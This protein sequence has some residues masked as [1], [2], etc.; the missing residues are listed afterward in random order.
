MVTPRPVV[1][2]SRDGAGALLDRRQVES[3]LA[4]GELPGGHRAAHVEGLLAAEVAEVLG[5]LL[6]RSVEVEGISE[7]EG[8]VDL[9][10]A[11]EPDVVGVDVE[12]T[13]L[14][15][16]CTAGFCFLG[17]EAD[18][19][20][21]DEAVELGEADLVRGRGE[22]PVHVGGAC[23]GEK[24]GGVS[25]APGLPHLEVTGHDPGIDP[26]Q[27]VPQLERPSDVPLAGLRRHPEGGGELVGVE[28]PH[29][30]GT[31]SGEGEA[32]VAEGLDVGRGHAVGI[33]GV[34]GVI[35]RPVQHLL[36]QLHLGVTRSDLRVRTASTAGSSARLDLARCPP[37]NATR[38]GAHRAAGSR[39]RSRRSRACPG[40]RVVR[41]RSSSRRGR[42]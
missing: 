36:Q 14:I 25:D 10:G 40:P 18:L 34:D 15:G 9:H 5:T 23:F 11:L 24:Q 31:R 17:V 21:V 19:G 33:G 32:G 39:S 27:P 28:L 20:F 6:D 8:A 1:A 41:R 35:D 38:R 42:R 16:C 4:S 2:G 26:R 7:V 12:P 13:V 37:S 29:T 22:H 30:R 3:E